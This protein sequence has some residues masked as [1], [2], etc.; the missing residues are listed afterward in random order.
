MLI[1]EIVLLARQSEEDR[2]SNRKVWNDSDTV[3]HM[4][5]TDRS[6]IGLWLAAAGSFIAWRTMGA[7]DFHGTVSGLAFAEVVI[8]I[9]F[10]A[11]FCGFLVTTSPRRAAP[12]LFIL[13]GL[14]VVAAGVAP[15]VRPLGDSWRVRG[16]HPTYLLAASGVFV[17]A[18]GVFARIEARRLA[19]PSAGARRLSC[20]L[21]RRPPRET[22]YP[23]LPRLRHRLRGGDRLPVQPLSQTDH[24]RL[25]LRARARFSRV[26]CWP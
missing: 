11:W 19:R 14:M 6:S 9:A 12:G 24:A 13:G 2:R 10:A 1:I 4:I 3:V 26:A 18:A 25:R 16:F 23:V 5:W 8:A 22:P 17:L 20:R 15:L 21:P 7:V